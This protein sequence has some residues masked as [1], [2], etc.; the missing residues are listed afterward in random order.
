VADRFGK[1][2]RPQAGVIHRLQDTEAAI[3]ANTGAGVAVV[4]LVVV[5]DTATRDERAETDV[6][7]RVQHSHRR[8]RIGVVAVAKDCVNV[9]DDVFVDECQVERPLGP[10]QV[11]LGIIR[12]D[13][14]SLAVSRAAAS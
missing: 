12:S 5:V 8:G 10:R 13:L 3:G 2:R 14:L 11:A 6:S 9:G 4:V 7:L 1:N